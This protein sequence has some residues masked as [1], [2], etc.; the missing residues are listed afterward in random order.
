M[1]DY[2]VKKYLNL[3]SLFVAGNI[4]AVE[5]EHRYLTLFKN[6]STDYSET[7]FLILDQLFG[8][9]DAFCADPLLRDEFDLDEQQLRQACIQTLEKLELMLPQKSFHQIAVAA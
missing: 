3:I 4:S 9:V 5:F 6:D 2:S 7:L 1:N 8:D